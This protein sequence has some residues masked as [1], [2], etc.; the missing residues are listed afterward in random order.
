MA[1]QPMVQGKQN[2]AAYEPQNK[3]NNNAK[4]T[5]HYYSLTP[6]DLF[7]YTCLCVCAAGKQQVLRQEFEQLLSIMFNADVAMDKDDI[8]KLRESGVF[9]PQT[10]WVTDIRN[11]EPGES[12]TGGLIIRG[13]LRTTRTVV[14]A[15]LC[16]K[17]KQLFGELVLCGS[18]K[19]CT[20][21]A[22]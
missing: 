6:A 17:V 7:V 22:G 9:G 8:K 20:C 3:Q 10:F 11:L 5:M 16:D 21:D 19:I 15:A 13:N 18:P 1:V 14:F 2:V 4:T 12:R